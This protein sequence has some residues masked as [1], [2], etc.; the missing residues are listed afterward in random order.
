MAQRIPLYT[1]QLSHPLCRRI[2]EIGD[3]I[4]PRGNRRLHAFATNH[5]ILRLG[6]IFQLDDAVTH[7]LT[8]EGLVDVFRAE[9]SNWGFEAEHFLRRS[10]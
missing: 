9:W 5:A 2:D 10:R 3:A 8:N 6:R 4:L 7:T 1:R